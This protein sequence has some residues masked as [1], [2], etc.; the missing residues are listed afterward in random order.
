MARRRKT[1]KPR[2]RSY[3][4][5]SSMGAVASDLLMTSLGVGVGAVIARQADKV[6]KFDTKINSAIKIG[7][8][9]ALPKFIKEPFVKDLGL[10]M[11]AMGGADLVGSFVPAL[12]GADEVMVVSG[13]RFGA[14]DTIGEDIAEV[15][16]MDISTVNGQDEIGYSEE[17]DY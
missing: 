7:V 9:L 11:V 15:N 5:R 17:M 12:G 8:G 3:K 14:I 1:S 16:G 13:T 4:R 6:L 10:G 2:R